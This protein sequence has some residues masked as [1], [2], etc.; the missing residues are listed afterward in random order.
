MV[1]R[2]AHH[3]VSVGILKLNG[4]RQADLCVQ[5]AEY[6]ICPFNLLFLYQIGVVL[7]QEGLHYCVPFVHEERNSIYCFGPLLG[8]LI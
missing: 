4:V 2:H 5:I 3:R 6:F 1:H 7:I 8:R